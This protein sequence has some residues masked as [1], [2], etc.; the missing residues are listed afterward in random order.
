MRM[1]IDYRSLNANSII[2]RYPLPRIDDILDR[3]GAATIYSKIDLAQGYHQV[4]IEPAD[5]HKTAFQ[6]HFGLFEYT[7]L[8]FGLCN[9]PSTFQRLMNEVF[10]DKLD[11]FVTVYL[12]DILVFSANP[13]EHDK[14]LRWVFSQLRKHGLKAKLKKCAFGL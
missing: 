11:I 7:V 14:H 3:L 1:C 4:N 2:D 9:A 10:Q 6:S 12:D 8:P 5:I 13:A